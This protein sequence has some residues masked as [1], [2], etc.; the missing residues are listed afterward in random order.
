MF[1][2]LTRLGAAL[3]LSFCLAL[4]LAWGWDQSDEASAAQ[5][6]ATGGDAPLVIHQ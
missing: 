6:P 1:E 3:L 4:L 5:A 2:I